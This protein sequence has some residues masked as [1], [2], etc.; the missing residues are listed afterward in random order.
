MEYL[1]NIKC[2]KIVKLNHDEQLYMLIKIDK[3]EKFLQIYYN[4]NFIFLLYLKK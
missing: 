1:N 2:F 4:C 3:F